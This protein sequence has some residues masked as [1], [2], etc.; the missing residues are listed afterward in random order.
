MLI[1]RAALFEELASIP[2]KS[3]DARHGALSSPTS[4]G[5]LL[6]TVPGTLLSA[7]LVRMAADAPLSTSETGQSSPMWS[8]PVSMAYREML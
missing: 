8:A 3:L 7:S 2:P 5:S 1:A 4:A 6:S